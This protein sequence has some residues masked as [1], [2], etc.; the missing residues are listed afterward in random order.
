MS[1]REAGIEALYDL[2]AALRHMAGDELPEVIE[3]RRSI[4]KLVERDGSNT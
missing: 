2:F 4:L 1:S 3:L